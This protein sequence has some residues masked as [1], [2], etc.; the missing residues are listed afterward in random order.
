MKYLLLT[1]ETNKEP[2][3]AARFFIYGGLIIPLEHLDYVDDEIASIRHRA[4][5]LPTD[6]F[7]FETN[8]YPRERVSAEEFATA[9][10]HVIHLCHDVGCVF[11]VHVILHKIVVNQDLL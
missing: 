1:D 10:D 5:Y 2:S 7:K 8:S 4:G 9:K 3:K 11:I 6:E